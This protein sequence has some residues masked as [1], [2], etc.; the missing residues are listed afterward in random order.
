MFLL[1]VGLEVVERRK[2]RTGDWGGSWTVSRTWFVADPI[3]LLVH[4]ASVVSIVW[5]SNRY[6][7]DKSI[8]VIVDCPSCDDVPCLLAQQ[9]NGRLRL[10][11]DPVKSPAVT[12]QG[13]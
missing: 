10:V 3:C 11:S 2:G 8:T 5:S 4:G 6:K 12:V 1:C 9:S 7:C 13:C